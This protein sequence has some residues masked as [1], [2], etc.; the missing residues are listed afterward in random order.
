MSDF[1]SSNCACYVTRYLFNSAIDQEVASVFQLGVC[2]IHNSQLRLECC[3]YK[4]LIF[5]EATTLISPE[6][7]VNSNRHLLFIQQLIKTLL[8]Y[9]NCVVYRYRLELRFRSR[10]YPMDKK[11]FTFCIIRQVFSSGT[12]C[13]KSIQIFFQICVKAKVN[14]PQN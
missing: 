9:I 14:P 6:F 7:Y 1:I 5:P 8:S 2:T 10:P 3:W 12:R 11:W 13:N 4:I